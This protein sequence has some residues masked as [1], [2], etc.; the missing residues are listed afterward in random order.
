MTC[1]SNH[2]S[3]ILTCNIA[4]LL[5]LLNSQARG[6]LVNLTSVLSYRA[7]VQQ[8]GLLWLG[9]QEIGYNVYGKRSLGDQMS[10]PELR[11]MSTWPTILYVVIEYFISQSISI[12]F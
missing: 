6:S 10:L 12:L 4:V 7:A 9:S 8:V 3:K 1:L 5:G 11:R 2:G